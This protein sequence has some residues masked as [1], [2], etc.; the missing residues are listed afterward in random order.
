MPYTSF[1]SYNIISCNNRFKFWVFH[2]QKKTAN[3][4]QNLIQLGGLSALSRNV[5]SR[6]LDLV[7]LL[8]YLLM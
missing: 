5:M 4:M 1:V 7:N 6:F 3:A 2:L 8:I